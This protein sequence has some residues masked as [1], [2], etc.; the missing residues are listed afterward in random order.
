MTSR[1][2]IPHPQYVFS[3]KPDHGSLFPVLQ[4]MS[5]LLAQSGHADCAQRCPLSG[6]KRTSAGAD[7]TS[8]F[9]PKRTLASALHMSAPDPIVALLRDFG[10]VRQ[11]PE[12]SPSER[13][14]RRLA[15]LLVWLRARLQPP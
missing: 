10:A 3:H 2:D 1:G 7:P 14:V 11:M 9:D 12:C 15:C 5:L 6:V 8:A 13:D 4:C